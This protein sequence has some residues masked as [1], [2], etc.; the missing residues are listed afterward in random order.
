M[1]PLLL[2]LLLLTTPAVAT[3]N[4]PLDNID[5]DT[6]CAAVFLELDDAVR[7]NI[8]SKGQALEIHNRCLHYWG[9]DTAG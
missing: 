5:G 1:K 8:I 7:S 4:H 3:S 6:M 2:S 9:V